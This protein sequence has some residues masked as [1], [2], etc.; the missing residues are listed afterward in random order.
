MK[1][2][3]GMIMAFGLFVMSSVWIGQV[4]G[5]WRP[6]SSI[7]QGVLGWAVALAAILVGLYLLDVGRGLLRKMKRGQ[8]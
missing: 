7:E 5:R 2:V 8:R 4:I 1:R 3:L 6:C